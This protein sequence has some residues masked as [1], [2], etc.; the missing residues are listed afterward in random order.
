MKKLYLI[1][2]KFEKLLPETMKEKEIEVI[3]NV[4]CGGEIRE[5]SGVI[6][7]PGYPQVWLIKEMQ[8][9]L[10]AVRKD[11]NLSDPQIRLKQN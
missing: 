3:D 2:K 7:S 9:I 6:T 8:T 5:N 4:I 1:Y 11:K 10:V